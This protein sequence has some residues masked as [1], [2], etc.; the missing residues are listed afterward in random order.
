MERIQFGRCHDWARIRIKNFGTS[1]SGISLLEIS[2][3]GTSRETQQPILVG[4]VL[5]ND[6]FL[7]PL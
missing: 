6:F 7:L 4:I 5:L 1:F 3:L 2:L